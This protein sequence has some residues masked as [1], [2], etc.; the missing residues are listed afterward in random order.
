M[1]PSWVNTVD[2]VVL[3]APLVDDYGVQRPDWS[4]E[5]ER[6][7][8]E[9]CVWVPVSSGEVVAG[10]EALSGDVRLLAPA[11]ADVTGHDHIEAPDG[12]RDYEVI[13]EPLRLASPTGALDHV[14]LLL[15]RWEG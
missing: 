4:G 11:G 8:L 12:G 13:G 15:R 6:G 14:E 1:F 7:V 9:G 5:L 2:V 3:R 10:R